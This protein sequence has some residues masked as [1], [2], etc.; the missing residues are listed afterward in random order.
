MIDRHVYVE[1]SL[2]VT[3]LTYSLYLGAWIAI[4]DNYESE[5]GN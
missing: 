4:D 5:S 3:I 2:G 1:K